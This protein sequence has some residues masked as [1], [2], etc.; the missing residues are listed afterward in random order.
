[1]QAVIVT[2]LLVVG[3]EPSKAH[4]GHISGVFHLQGQI[5][6]QLMGVTHLVVELDREFVSFICVYR[7]LIYELVLNLVRRCAY[8]A[9]VLGPRLY[10]K[11][12][13]KQSCTD[14][15]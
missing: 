12:L 8:T 15:K 4:I 3:P 1:M 10:F 14:S 2:C 9:L 13:S 5:T 6:V 7:I 11:G